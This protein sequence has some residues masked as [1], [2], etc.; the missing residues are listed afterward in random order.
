MRVRVPILV[1]IPLC[2]GTVG[3][4]W[5]W[6]TRHMDFVSL[7]SG[8][9]L[10]ALRAAAE[11]E[12]AREIA[13]IA[14]EAASG[15]PMKPAVAEPTPAP[16]PPPTPPAP[17]L[18]DLGISP[19]LD[20]YRDRKSAS[21]EAIEALAK[22]LEEKGESTRALLAW[23]RLID[24]VSA[25]EE[26]TKVAHQNILRLRGAS[27]PWVTDKNE[28]KPVVLRAEVPAAQT[29]ALKPLLE[30]SAR[31]L[32]EASSG[33]ISVKLELITAKVATPPKNAPKD[34]SSKP[35]TLR[36]HVPGQAPESTE[37]ITATPATDADVLAALYHLIANRMAKTP[38]LLPPRT[39]AS[40]EI[41]VEAL[42]SHLTRLQWREWIAKLGQ[43][44]P[45][46]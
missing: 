28:S 42:R 3:G 19:G 12:K 13:A 36:L 29:E 1:V 45:T 31:V 26:Q 46:Q 18:G 17:D 41:P 15:D 16:P 6:N 20:L 2:L 14:A 4:V 33:Q 5:W 21:P 10:E 27:L 39:L 22:A 44:E 8:A 37:V 38:S 30:R 43:T 32:G 11:E 40:S 24:T 9:R 23:E 25:S 7:P 34:A 35:I